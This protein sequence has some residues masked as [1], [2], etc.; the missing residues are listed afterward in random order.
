MNAVGLH[1]A[2]GSENTISDGLTIGA[3]LSHDPAFETR[4]S[5][6]MRYCFG[7]MDGAAPQR[8]PARTT[9]IEALAASPAHRETRIHDAQRARIAQIERSI[10]QRLEQFSCNIPDICHTDIKRLRGLLQGL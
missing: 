4:F 2:A 6:D 9:T 3:T 10:V 1:W 5:A 7:S 8:Q